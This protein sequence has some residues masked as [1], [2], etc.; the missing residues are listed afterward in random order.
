MNIK[1]LATAAVLLVAAGS[2]LAVPFNTRPIYDGAG[3]TTLDSLQGVFA[4]IGSTIDAKNDQLD[5]AYWHN[6]STGA[7]S[8]Y[9]ASLTWDTDNFPFEFGIYEF[10]NI[11]NKVAIFDDAT[12]GT[13]VSDPGDWTTINF[14]EAGGEVYT[15][16]HNAQ[17][18]ALNYQVGYTNDYMDTFGFYFSWN[19]G[20]NIW[21]GD[22]ALNG[23]TAAMLAYEANGDAVDIAGQ[24][25]PSDANHYYI[26]MEG[27]G[28]ITDFN[29][30]VVQ[31][32]S[33]IPAPAPATLALMGLGLLGMARVA[34]RRKV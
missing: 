20:T 31:M 12:T 26:A 33:I 28:G 14:N 7:N 29:D 10:G 19:D 23:G 4:G 13:G 16:Y 17:S 25:S 30:I 22:D 32:E 8:T 1:Q 18:A 2:A 34:S 24:T 15:E 21:Y 9:V 11:G 5:N 27:Y 3:D 6:Q